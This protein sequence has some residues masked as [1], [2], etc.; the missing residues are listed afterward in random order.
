MILDEA[1]GGCTVVLG[2]ADWLSRSGEEA[3][4]KEEW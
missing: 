2:R 3:E 4:M 1:Q